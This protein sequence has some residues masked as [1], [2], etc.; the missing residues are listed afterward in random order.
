[1]ARL[2]CP[3]YMRNDYSLRSN[4]SYAGVSY[5]KVR[6]VDKVPKLNARINL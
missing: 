4:V 2:Y 6:N 1:M 5:V 3:M